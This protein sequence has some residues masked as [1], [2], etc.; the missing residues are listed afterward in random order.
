MMTQISRW[1]VW[2]SRIHRCRGFGIQSPTDYAF[3]R[4]VVNEHW[5]YYAY[6]ELKGDDWLTEKL[7]RLYFRLA[8]WRQP[9]TMVADR[10]QRYWQAG[11]RKTVFTATV[12][13]V[14]LARVEV[15]DRAAWESVVQHCD[16]HSV[17][18]VEGIWRS[19]AQWQAIKCDE[20]TGITF[21]LYYCGIVFFEK[22]RYKHHYTI[23]F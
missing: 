17:V 19:R 22:K 7:G 12:A 8:N 2:L 14:E 20:R 18:V 11:C 4:Y 13:T 9:Q 23:N 3:V 6:E 1:L 21:D 10:Y 5:P 15:E 16:E